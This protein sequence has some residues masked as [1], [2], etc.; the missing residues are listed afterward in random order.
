MAADII[1]TACSDPSFITA[2][3]VI[4]KF[5]ERETERESP[6]PP[7][8]ITVIGGAA[9]ILHAYLL[10]GRNTQRMQESIR[11]VPQTSDIDIAMW[12]HS[13]LDKDTFKASN[14]RI[15]RRIRAQFSDINRIMP[16]RAIMENLSPSSIDTFEIDVPESRTYGKMTTT[17]HVD[18]IINGQR[19]TVIDMAIKNAIYS[20]PIRNER[21]RS[22]IP[23]VQNITYTDK[24]NTTL[25]RVKD[26]DNSLGTPEEYVRVPTLERLI[27]QQRFAIE[28]MREPAKL[29]K[30]HAR[31]S[32][33]E[34]LVRSVTR[35]SGRPPL[36]RGPSRR[37]GKRRTYKK[38]KRH[39][40]CHTKRQTKRR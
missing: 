21:N 19:M 18:F 25:L 27:Q 29:S 4:I 6:L 16:L 34:P 28:A 7:H 36:H 8:T 11:D 13:E 38:N 20:Q 17:I 35:N 23:V 9:F 26:R 37:G 10:N 30:Y 3:N 33:L 12:Y 39:T 15:E 1:R 5:C 40:K 2:I 14:E 22:T 24:Q 31:L 32:Y